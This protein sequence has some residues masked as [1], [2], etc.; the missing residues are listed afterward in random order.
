MTDRADTREH[1]HRARLDLRCPAGLLR[2]AGP[3]PRAAHRAFRR[4]DVSRRRRHDPRRVLRQARRRRRSCRRPRSRRSAEFT[5]VYEEATQ[6]Y[7]HVFSLHISAEMSGTVR[8]AQQAAEAFAAVEVYDTRTVTAAMSLCAERLR[9]RL[10]RGCTLDEI[11]AYIDPHHRALAPAHPRRDPRVSASRRAHRARRL[12]G[13]RGPRHQA[14][15]PERRRH[16]GRLRQGARPEEGA[17]GDGAGSSKRTRRPT[18]S[19][20]T[21][22]S[23][24]ST[25]RSRRGSGS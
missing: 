21:C 2:P 20:T 5:A 24:R 25:K 18:T 15:D 4:R 16:V 22:S 14:S 9:A 11:R 8:A 6:K 12:A 3:V 19:C 23:T 10:E 1:R 7:E 13:G 17:G